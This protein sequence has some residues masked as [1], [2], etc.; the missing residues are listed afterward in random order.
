MRPSHVGLLS[1][2]VVWLIAFGMSCMCLFPVVI[3]TG[4]ITSTVS[5]DFVARILSP[6]LCPPGTEPEIFTYETT[7]TDE[8]GFETPTTAFEM[9]CLDQEGALVKDLGPTYAFIW[10][11]LLTAAGAVLAAILAFALASPLSVL[12]SRWAKRRSNTSKPGT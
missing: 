12:A 4:S 11:G 3:L 2:S 8:I 5:A 6:Y 7:T 1:G 10:I 9:R